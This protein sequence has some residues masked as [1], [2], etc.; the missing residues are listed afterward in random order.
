MPTLHTTPQ[1]Y[2]DE[3]AAATLRYVAWLTTPRVRTT[4][5]EPFVP[6]TPTTNLIKRAILAGI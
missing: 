3:Q 4:P 2:Y 6:V 1:S 5:P